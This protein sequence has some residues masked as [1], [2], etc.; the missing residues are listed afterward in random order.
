MPM[1]YPHTY[2]LRYLCNLGWRHE[3][4]PFGLG[5]QSRVGAVINGAL[6][7][8]TRAQQSCIS[9]SLYARQTTTLARDLE[10][11][12]DHTPRQVIRTKVP[13]QMCI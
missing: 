8:C 7:T 9:G 1:V 4:V 11:N 2:S 10:A 6:R 12:P 5:K 13:C 3:V